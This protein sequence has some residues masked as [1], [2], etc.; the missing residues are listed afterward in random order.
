M[1]SYRRLKRAF[2]LTLILLIFLIFTLPIQGQ[3]R[4]TWTPTHRCRQYETASAR[5]EEKPKT[6]DETPY[7][8]PFG[9]LPVAFGYAGGVPHSRSEIL[10]RR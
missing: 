8:N 9:G 4:E 5:E 1:K 2:V 3:G 6:K 10:D 7:S